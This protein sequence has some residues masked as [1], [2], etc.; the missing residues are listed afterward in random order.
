MVICCSQDEIFHIP[1]GQ[2]L[3]SGDFVTWDPKITTFP[4]LYGLSFA[5]H[6]IASCVGSADEVCSP[7]GLR[8]LN[9]VVSFLIAPLAQS[10]R[11]QVCEN[12]LR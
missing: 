4:G 12:V 3:C 8:L 1:Q 10:I 11:R 9:V 2:S 6:W 5:V 7:T